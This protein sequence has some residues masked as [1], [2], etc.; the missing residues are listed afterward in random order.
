MLGKVT[1][2]KVYCF[3]CPVYLAMI[4]LEDEELARLFTYDEQKLFLLLFCYYFEALSTTQRVSRK[5]PDYTKTKVNNE[6]LFN[7]YHK[8]YAFVAVI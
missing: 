6:S 5:S 1:G 3:V 4:L 7:G 2:K 8:S